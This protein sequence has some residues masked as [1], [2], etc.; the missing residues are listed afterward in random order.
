MSA[1]W[2]MTFSGFVEDSP[3]GKA[4]FEKLFNDTVEAAR[5]ALRGAPGVK[6]MD[7]QKDAAYPTPVPNA[8]GEDAVFVG[9]LRESLTVP[10]GLNLWVVSDNVRKGAALNS[11]QIAEVLQ[12][13]L[14]AR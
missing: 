9:R 3:K 4:A 1:Q 11:V 14:P 12:D 7:G 8:A 5:A 2:H 13:L 10:G 6:L